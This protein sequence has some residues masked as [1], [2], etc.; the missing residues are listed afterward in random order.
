MA[1]DVEALKSLAARSAEL[2]GGYNNKVLTKLVRAEYA[3]VFYDDKSVLVYKLWC[4][5]YKKPF[6]GYVMVDP[7]SGECRLTLDL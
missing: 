1:Y 7:E 6:E 4:K 2:Y 3:G 5:G